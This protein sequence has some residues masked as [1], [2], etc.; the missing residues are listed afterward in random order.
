MADAE[1]EANATS[2][3]DPGDPAAGANDTRRDLDRAPPAGGSK[4]AATPLPAVA[5]LAGF[6]LAALARRR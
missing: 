2:K 4:P 6:A 3:G 1:A 5:A